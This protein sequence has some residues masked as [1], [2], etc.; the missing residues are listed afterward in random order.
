MWWQAVGLGLG[1]RGGCPMRGCIS[2]F[3]VVRMTPKEEKESKIMKLNMD[4]SDSLPC[5]LMKLYL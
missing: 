4:Q 2:V 5:V 3:L 1:G